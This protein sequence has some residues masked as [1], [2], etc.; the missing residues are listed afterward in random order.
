MAVV[1][2]RPVRQD[3]DDKSAVAARQGSGWRLFPPQEPTFERPFCLLQGCRLSCDILDF[4]RRFSVGEGIVNEG[5][6]ARRALALRPAHHILVLGIYLAD[7]HYGITVFVQLE[8]VGSDPGANA[9]TGADL[10]IYVD[11]HGQFAFT[12][13]NSMP[14]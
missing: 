3:F 11:F 5:N 6:G 4:A 13:S 1:E 9:K 12:G 14:M 10:R 8:H 7:Q 2:L